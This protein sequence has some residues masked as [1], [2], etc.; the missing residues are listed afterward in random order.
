MPET[1]EKIYFD[2]NP[3][4]YLYLSVMFIQPVLNLPNTF[5]YLDLG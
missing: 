4:I 2:N 3:L 5:K 1:L